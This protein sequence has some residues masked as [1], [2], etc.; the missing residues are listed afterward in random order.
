MF[1]GL[2]D[3]GKLMKQAKE[4]RSKMK[5]VQKQLKKVLTKGRDSRGWVEAEADGEVSFTYIKILSDE[6]LEL[7]NKPDLERAIAQAVNE[8]AKKSKDI[9]TQKLSEVSG[10]LNIPGLT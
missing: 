8:A 5:D 10:G 2:K 4:M 7:R 1:D 3:M 9:A 6:A